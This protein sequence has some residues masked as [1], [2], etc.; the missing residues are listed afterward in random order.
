MLIIITEK[1]AAVR[2]WILAGTTKTRSSCNYNL[3]SVQYLLLCISWATWASLV[4]LKNGCKS[5]LKVNRKNYTRLS[6]RFNKPSV[7]ASNQSCSTNT[8]EQVL[9]GT[10]WLMVDGGWGIENS[11]GGFFQAPKKHIHSVV[12]N[13]GLS[14]NESLAGSCCLSLKRRFCC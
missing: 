2:F 8:L 14:N 9:F 5:K 7:R 4:V 11:A 6:Y 1:I 3:C 12:L 10:H 13:F